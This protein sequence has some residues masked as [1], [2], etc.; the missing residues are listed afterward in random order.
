MAHE[1]FA[2]NFT[3]MNQ[4]VYEI[5]T[6]QFKP[7]PVAATLTHFCD[8]NLSLITVITDAPILQIS[9]HLNFFFY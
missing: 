8:S 5:I 1:K 7:I 4:I 3:V 9:I 2:L 6:N